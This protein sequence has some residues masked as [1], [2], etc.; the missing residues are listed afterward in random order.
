[1][2]SL[3]QLCAFWFFTILFSFLFAKLISLCAPGSHR[4]KVIQFLAGDLP[5]VVTQ[6]RSDDLVCPVLYVSEIIIITKVVCSIFLPIK[7]STVEEF[8]LVQRC[9]GLFECALL[10]MHCD[11]KMCTCNML[12]MKSMFILWGF[13]FVWWENYSVEVSII[14]GIQLCAKIVLFE[15]ALLLLCIVCIVVRQVYL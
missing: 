8:Y 13:V 12:L 14:C 9:L 3:W 4:Q 7:V 6:N 11:K 5:E 15:C 2:T 1:M 10:S